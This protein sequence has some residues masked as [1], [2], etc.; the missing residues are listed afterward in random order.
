MICYVSTLHIGYTSGADQLSVFVHTERLNIILIL[1]NL[2]V[3]TKSDNWSAADIL[4]ICNVETIQTIS[5]EVT[6]LA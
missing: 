6:E 1:S 3:C 2:S 5:D 4:P